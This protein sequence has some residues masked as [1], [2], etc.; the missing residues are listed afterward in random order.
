M[1]HVQQLVLVDLTLADA[2]K[3]L[4]VLD[5]VDIGRAAARRLDHLYHHD[6]LG[7]LEGRALLQQPVELLPRVDLGVDLE[8]AQRLDERLVVQG[9]EIGEIVVDDVLLAA[10]HEEE[11]K[12]H[13][14]VVA[15]AQLKVDHLHAEDL[16]VVA[17][18][19]H[20]VVDPEVV[21]HEGRPALWK[22]GIEELMIRNSRLGGQCKLHVVIFL[23]NRCG[24]LCCVGSERS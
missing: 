13:H 12:V 20:H 21:V 17:V 4:R 10:R 15:H 16:A 1:Q 18:P 5:A 14:A 19:V 9:N 11:D 2:E 23:M 22:R 3:S 24:V 8:R 6:A 7:K